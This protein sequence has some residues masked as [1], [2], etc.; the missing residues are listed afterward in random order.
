VLVFYCISALHHD[1]VIKSLLRWTPRP[2]LALGPESARAGPDREHVRVASESCRIF[3][4]DQWVVYLLHWKIR[5][6]RCEKSRFYPVLAKI[7]I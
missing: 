1:D 2:G 5:T 7:R 4:R 3:P 6:T